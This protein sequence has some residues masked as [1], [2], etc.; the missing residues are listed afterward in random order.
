MR[1]FN[2]NFELMIQNQLHQ[3]QIIDIGISPVHVA[4]NTSG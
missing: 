3:Y 4:L 2:H 1:C